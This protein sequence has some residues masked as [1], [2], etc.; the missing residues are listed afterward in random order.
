M[1][2][3]KNMIIKGSVFSGSPINDEVKISFTKELI[4]KYIPALDKA[5][6]EEMKGLKAIMVIMTSKE[7][8]YKGTRSFKTNNPGNVGNVDSGKNNSFKTLEEGVA[9]Q[10]E[11]VLRVANGKHPAYP[12][13]RV[14]KIP[15]FYSK[16][17]AA[18]QK[19]YGID[20]Y[21][22]GY[23]FTYTGQLDQFVKIYSTG[24]R[25]GNSYLSMIISYFKNLGIHVTP[26]TT[27]KEI[28]NIQDK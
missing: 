12:L 24:A 17:I 27:L 21:L 15:P 14:K 5:V 20:P 25:G 16:E 4:D 8:F 3:Y 6:P 1:S 23:V 13:G 19:N 22:P 28:I 7:G 18:N 10:M 9:A 2:V 11:Y 26:E